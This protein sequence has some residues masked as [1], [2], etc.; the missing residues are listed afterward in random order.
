MQLF[1][2]ILVQFKVVDLE[3]LESLQTLHCLEQQIDTLDTK[4]IVAEV[5]TLDALHVGEWL[6]DD[7]K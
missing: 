3:N 7:L 6:L 5:N 1:E 2:F 4:H